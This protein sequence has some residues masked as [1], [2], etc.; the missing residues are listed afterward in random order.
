MGIHGA[1]G[2][3]RAIGDRG[4]V[5]AG[6]WAVVTASDSVAPLAVAPTASVA[7]PVSIRA[8]PPARRRVGRHAP[9]AALPR[10]S[11]PCTKCAHAAG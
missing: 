10:R 3:R 2:G 6:S 8:Q 1:M 4:Y 11:R 5:S 9:R 7:S